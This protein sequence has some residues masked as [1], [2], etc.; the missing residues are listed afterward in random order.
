MVSSATTNDQ[1][2]GKRNAVTAEKQDRGGS[3]KVCCSQSETLLYNQHLSR[4]ECGRVLQAR[5]G[6]ISHL[7]THRA[8]QSW[9]HQHHHRRSYQPFHRDSCDILTKNNILLVP[10][11]Y[12]NYSGLVKLWYFVMVV[13]SYALAKKR[14]YE[15]LVIK[16]ND[17]EFRDSRDAPRNCFSRFSRIHVISWA[18]SRLNINV[19]HG[20]AFWYS[21]LS[22]TSLV[23]TTLFTYIF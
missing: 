20:I 7:C 17:V 18:T 23:L 5:I 3:E 14:H 11:L 22:M 9:H 4:P 15:L 2:V 10:N 12:N 1:L 8:N 6:L 16:I 19:L 13:V 21:C